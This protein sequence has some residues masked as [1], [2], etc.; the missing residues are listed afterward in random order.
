MK[1]ER[2]EHVQKRRRIKNK[3]RSTIRSNSGPRSKM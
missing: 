3:N 2:K 1:I